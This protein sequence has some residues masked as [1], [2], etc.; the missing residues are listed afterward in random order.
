MLRAAAAIAIQKGQMNP[1]VIKM[2]TV[3]PWV[4]S[5]G[6]TDV[7]EPSNGTSKPKSDFTRKV[8]ANSPTRKNTTEYSGFLYAKSSKRLEYAS[9]G[10]MEYI[11]MV[12]P[13]AIIEIM[14]AMFSAQIKGMV[15]ESPTKLKYVFT[16]ETFASTK[17][18]PTTKLHHGTV[19]EMIKRAIM[20]IAASRPIR[21]ILFSCNIFLFPMRWLECLVLFVQGFRCLFH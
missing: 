14:L 16:G 15:K 10:L 18:S 6:I 8:V 5:T 3:A 7:M 1:A 21:L 12:I 11:S 19:I 13:P 4:M 9:S 2:L 17:L 20:V